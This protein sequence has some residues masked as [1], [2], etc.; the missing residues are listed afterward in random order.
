MAIQF[1]PEFVTKEDFKS[2]WGVDLDST[3]R[4]DDAQKS[5]VFLAR[6]ERQLKAYID[7]GSFRQY[8]WDE[9]KLNQKW[10]EALQTAILTQAYYVYRNSDI[11]TDSGYDPDKGVIAPKQTLE[12]IKVCP[13]AITYLKNAGLFSQ[14]MQNHRRH[15]DWLDR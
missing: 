8:H 3:L 15:M 1:K 10:L 14:T 7:E 6:I 13:E 5:N 11:S 12:A 2:M 4:G 9:I